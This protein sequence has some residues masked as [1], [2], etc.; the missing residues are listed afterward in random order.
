MIQRII[1]NIYLISIAV[2]AIT[3][4]CNQTT[5]SVKDLEAEVMSI[6]DEVMPKMGTL[7]NLKKQLKVKVNE[8]DSG[9][10][11]R[12]SLTLLIQG[13]EE[14]DEEMM[15]WMRNYKKPSE[16]MSDEHAIEY[17][18]QE[19]NKIEEVKEKINS[20]EEAAKA[21]LGNN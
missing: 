20:S 7:M 1:S 2:L 10:N 17:L 12:D 5:E 11:K 6:H 13:L 18:K 9:S 14:A 3:A 4:S 19:K 8:L 21:A 16:E 15:Q